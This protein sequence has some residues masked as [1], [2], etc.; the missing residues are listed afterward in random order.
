MSPQLSHTTTTSSPYLVNGFHEPQRGPCA[1]ENTNTPTPAC[2]FLRASAISARAFAIEYDASCLAS[3]T[4]RAPGVAVSGPK[5]DEQHHPSCSSESGLWCCH[6]LTTVSPSATCPLTR[7]ATASSNCQAVLGAALRFLLLGGYLRESP[8][9][10]A[11]EVGVGA[12]LLLNHPEKL[13]PH[14]GQS[15]PVVV[16]TRTG[17]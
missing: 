7:A 11:L 17:C 3:M 6:S 13:A 10:L 1:V 15:R 2:L 5:L 12:V 9:H 16:E 4:I 14:T 8:Q